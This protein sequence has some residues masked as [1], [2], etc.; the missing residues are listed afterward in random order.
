MWHKIELN[1]I[2]YWNI[3]QWALY[4]SNA[5]LMGCAL[6]ILQGVIDGGCYSFNSLTVQMFTQVKWNPSSDL[7]RE[8]QGQ[9]LS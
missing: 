9:S 1:S 7:G 8:A 2:L 5:E 6:W 4:S 3:E